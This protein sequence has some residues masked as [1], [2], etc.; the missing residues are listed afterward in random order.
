MNRRL[1]FLH[2]W[3][4]LIALL[5][6]LAW[7]VSGFFFAVVPKPRLMSTPVDGAHDITLSPET[8]TLASG[9]LAA[10]ARELGAG[11][12]RK[13]EIRGSDVGPVA[14]VSGSKRR[15]RLDATTGRER[16]VGCTLH[17]WCGRKNLPG[18]WHPHS[19]RSPA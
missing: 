3:I 4:S 15:V 10:R 14:V 6:L 8:V 1:Y 19:S 2:R 18:R 17:L 5:Q 7:S 9:D 12:I 11:E 13:I 16:T